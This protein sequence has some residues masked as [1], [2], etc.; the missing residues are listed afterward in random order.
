MRVR[1]AQL[2][3]VTSPWRAPRQPLPAPA[4]GNNCFQGLGGSHVEEEAIL[5]SGNSWPSLETVG[6]SSLR[7]GAVGTSGPNPERLLGVLQCTGPSPRQAC[8]AQM[9]AVSEK[10][11]RWPKHM[12][13]SASWTRGRGRSTGAKWG[14]KF[15][16]KGHGAEPGK[17]IWAYSQWRRK[18]LHSVSGKALIQ[19]DA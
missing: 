1:A 17:L 10:P 9:S 3:L 2:G 15:F 14:G 5:L 11:P 18:F 19:K 13:K 6:S 16:S 12:S 8:P 4:A 7:A